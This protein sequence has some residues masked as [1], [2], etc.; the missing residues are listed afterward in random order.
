M[1]KTCK[2]VG[3]GEVFAL[4]TITVGMMTPDELHALQN[5]VDILR[6]LDH[7][8]IVRLCETFMDRREARLLALASAR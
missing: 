6:S 4:K 5:E 2:R 3:T 7:P 8:S 1:V